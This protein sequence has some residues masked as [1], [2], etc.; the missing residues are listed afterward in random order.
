MMAWLEQDMDII[1]S[2]LWRAAAVW[3][4]ENAV[5]NDATAIDDFL[6]R[7]VYYASEERKEALI[8]T[9]CP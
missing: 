3:V 2:R 8:F 1:L 9:T 5:D 4:G 6:Q 7:V